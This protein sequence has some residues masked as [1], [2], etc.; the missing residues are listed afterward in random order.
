MNRQAVTRSLIVEGRLVALV[1]EEHLVDDVDEAV[2]TLHPQD[3]HLSRSRLAAL[4]L[5]FKVVKLLPLRVGLI[6]LATN[7]R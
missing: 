4:S 1:G 7:D 5:P 3:H 6:E 2:I